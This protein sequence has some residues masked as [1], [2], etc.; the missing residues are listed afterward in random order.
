VRSNPFRWE[1]CEEILG[2]MLLILDPEVDKVKLNPLRARPFG[3]C[4]I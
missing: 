4:A 1:I 3:N 2:D